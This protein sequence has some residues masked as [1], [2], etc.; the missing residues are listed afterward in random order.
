MLISSLGFQETPYPQ[1][2]HFGSLSDRGFMLYILVLLYPSP[3]TV[4]QYNI[5]SP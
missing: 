2:P 1:T 4:L 5:N 3:D